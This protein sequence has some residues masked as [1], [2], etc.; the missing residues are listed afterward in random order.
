MTNYLTTQQIDYL[1]RGVQEEIK[2]GVH[3]YER[4]A[5][6]TLNLLLKLAQLSSYSDDSGDFELK[7]VVDC[8]KKYA[9]L[10][11]IYF[12]VGAEAAHAV[13][14]AEQYWIRKDAQEICAKI[15]RR[16]E[17]ELQELLKK[18]EDDQ[19]VAE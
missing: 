15:E 4:E 2:N 3:F 1:N 19:E 18:Y 8:L 10:W 12:E 7:V 14:D 17:Q 9:R 6:E 16:Q 5:P 13:F 11:E